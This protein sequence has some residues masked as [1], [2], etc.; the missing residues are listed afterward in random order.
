MSLTEIELVNSN[1]NVSYRPLSGVLNADGSVGLE[2]AAGSASAAIS[3]PQAREN[4]AYGGGEGVIIAASDV[5]GIAS[6]AS[7]ALLFS[8][9][10]ETRAQADAFLYD[11]QGGNAMAFIPAGFLGDTG[12][13]FP[14]VFL[15]LYADA[16]VPQCTVGVG[17]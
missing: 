4:L 9:T 6:G 13:R 11:A 3:G 2:L 12:I 5:P 17:F 10:V 15:Q 1:G 16:N 8:I 14:R 7:T